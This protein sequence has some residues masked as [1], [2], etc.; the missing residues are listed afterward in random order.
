MKGNVAKEEKI[1]KMNKNEMIVRGLEKAMT[2][3]IQMNM[4]LNQKGKVKNESKQRQGMTE[5][6]V[7]NNSANDCKMK[8]DNH[9]KLT[10]INTKYI[11]QWLRCL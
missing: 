11:L 10:I 4:S 8:S 9:N 7:K 2:K 5:Q 3:N 6:S 1:S